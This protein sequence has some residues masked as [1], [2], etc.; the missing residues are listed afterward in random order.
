MLSRWMVLT[1]C[2]V[3]C[4]ALASAGLYEYRGTSPSCDDRRTLDKV[5]A[6]LRDDYHLDSIFLNN[7]RTLSGG[8]FSLSRECSAEVAEIRGNVNAADMPW[9]ELRYRI[10]EHDRATDP[11]ISVTLGGSVP[12]A[13]PAPS[14]W[15][16]LL[17]YL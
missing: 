1:L 3:V 9:R 14:L 10:E 11:A 2:P 17:E 12:L 15:E 6:V 5:D 8:L 4:L 16:T 13:R 7:I